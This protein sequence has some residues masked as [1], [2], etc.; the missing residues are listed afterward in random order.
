MDIK[1]FKEIKRRHQLASE[2]VVQTTSNAELEAQS[3]TH[4]ELVVQPSQPLES[5]DR[6]EPKPDM[7]LEFLSE[8]IGY[9]ES[10]AIIER[11]ESIGGSGWGYSQLLKEFRE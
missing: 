4:S 8:P 9:L 6:T 10:V 11:Q 5:I 3:E 1:K 2:P 7:Q